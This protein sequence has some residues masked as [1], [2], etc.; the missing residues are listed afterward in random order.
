M[1][2]SL[3]VGVWIAYRLYARWFWEFGWF[4]VGVKVL[5]CGSGFG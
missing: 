2:F 4:R 3:R 5:V 1:F